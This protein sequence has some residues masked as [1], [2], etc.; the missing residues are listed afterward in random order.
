MGSV[1]VAGMGVNVTSPE[2]DA[3]VRKMP[4]LI[5]I[6][7]KIYPSMLLEN[8]RVRNGSKRIKVIAKD[9]GI[10]EVLVSKKAGVPV[11]HNAEMY[12][13]YADP[14]KYVQMTATEIFSDS[15]NENKIKAGKSK[16]LCIVLASF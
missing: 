5:R 15:F 8:V 2:P 12:I 6:N 9:H 13:N 1:G 10:D 11:N 16:A 4:V 7:G 3:V 14:E